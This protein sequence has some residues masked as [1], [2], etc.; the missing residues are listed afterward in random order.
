M[1]DNTPKEQNSIPTSKVERSAK[2]VKTGF[3][4]RWELYKALFQKTV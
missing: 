3:Q 2:F 1:S 4:N